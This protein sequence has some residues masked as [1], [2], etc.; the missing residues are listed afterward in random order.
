MSPRGNLE[1]SVWWPDNPMVHTVMILAPTA[2][3]AAKEWGSAAHADGLIAD[4]D[5]VEVKV[6]LTK[7]GDAATPVTYR[8]AVQLLI[9][10]TA[11][12]IE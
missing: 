9:D 10:I 8:L 1:W 5:E 2:K 12:I 6:A 7:Q 4:D 3:E 11:R